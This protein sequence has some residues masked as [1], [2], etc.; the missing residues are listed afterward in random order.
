MLSLLQRGVFHLCIVNTQF[1]EIGQYDLLDVGMH[2]AGCRV[3]SSA[4]PQAFFN[5]K[6]VS[7]VK[8]VLL[9]DTVPTCQSTP[10]AFVGRSVL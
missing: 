9:L 8:K 4:H 6:K 1:T 3:M 7:P 2:Q 10:S 5:A